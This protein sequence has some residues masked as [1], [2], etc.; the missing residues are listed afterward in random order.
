MYIKVKTKQN[1]QKTLCPL[2]LLICEDESFLSFIL[3]WLVG[4]ADISPSAD[5]TRLS[6]VVASWGG[7]VKYVSLGIW[8]MRLDSV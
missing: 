5:D 1:K 4:K 3:S 2:P 7:Y 6:R 8:T